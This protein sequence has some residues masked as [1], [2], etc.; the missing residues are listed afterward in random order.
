ME[1]FKRYFDFSL[2]PSPAETVKSCLLQKSFQKQMSQTHTLLLYTSDVENF[3][4]VTSVQWLRSLWG[5]W[6]TLQGS[7]GPS[8]SHCRRRQSE[9]QR[10]PCTNRPSLWEET[11]RGRWAFTAGDAYAVIAPPFQRELL[12]KAPP[13]SLQEDV[14]PRL[15]KG[16]GFF[17]LPSSFKIMK[18]KKQQR[19]STWTREETDAFWDTRAIPPLLCAGPLLSLR[20][21]NQ[22]SAG[23]D[24]VFRAWE[25]IN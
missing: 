2:S 24:F 5:V 20:V 18:T 23:D 7:R 17:F 8:L 13:L 9:L 12:G 22:S 11:G 14:L 15:T 3:H 4:L 19:I 25:T 1:S 16:K 10:G 6:S 21:A